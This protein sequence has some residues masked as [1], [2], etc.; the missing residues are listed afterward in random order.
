MMVLVLI[1][2]VLLEVGFNMMVMGLFLLLDVVVE[3]EIVVFVVFV[4]GM[5]IVDGMVIVG[6]ILLG[7]RENV[8]E[9]I[10]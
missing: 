7:V 9:V 3:K 6:G 4:V 8:L 5:V 1:G 10:V 2:N